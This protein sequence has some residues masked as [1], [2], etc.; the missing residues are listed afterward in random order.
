MA[1]EMSRP[2]PPLRKYIAVSA[3][4]ETD[5]W[6]AGAEANRKLNGTP[7]ISIYWDELNVGFVGSDGELKRI[8]LHAKYQRLLTRVGQGVLP[9]FFFVRAAFDCHDPIDL[10]AVHI[11]FLNKIRVQ[12]NTESVQCL[13]KKLAYHNKVHVP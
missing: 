12:T 7:S 9:S 11:Y 13:S 8:R 1:S 4:G 5:G 3:V 10:G 6:M 2:S